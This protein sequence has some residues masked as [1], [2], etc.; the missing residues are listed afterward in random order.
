METPTSFYTRRHSEPLG[1]FLTSSTSSSH[2]AAGRDLSLSPSIRTKHLLPDID[3]PR[4]DAECVPRPATPSTPTSSLGGRSSTDASDALSIRSIFAL[5]SPSSRNRRSPTESETPPMN[6]HSTAAE[7][8][9]DVWLPKELAPEMVTVSA[10]KG[11]RL[12]IVADVWNRENN[13]ELFR[14][15]DHVMCH[16]R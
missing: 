7:H 15:L 1:G 3:S 12:S 11:N 6:V 8:T 9:L 5:E 14:P 2:I 16:R 13:C 4:A 10:K